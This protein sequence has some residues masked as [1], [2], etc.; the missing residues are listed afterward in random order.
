MSFSALAEVS[1]SDA[2][3]TRRLGAP[4]GALV[5]LVG[6]AFFKLATAGSLIAGGEPCFGVIIRAGGGFVVDACF[7][8]C[9]LIAGVWLPRCAFALGTLCGVVGAVDV[10]FA[11]RFG[12]P[13][14]ASQLA[15][16]SSAVPVELGWA[17][18][19][20]LVALA[21]VVFLASARR[22]TQPHLIGSVAVLLILCGVV[23][24]IVDDQ[25]QRRRLGLDDSPL[26]SLL[27]W[28]H[29]PATRAGDADLAISDPDA[30][31]S[32]PVDVDRQ[33][34]RPRHV[35]LFVS[36]STALGFVDDST[37]PR[38]MAL[39]GGHAASFQEHSAQSPISIK[40][41]FSLL[42]G[43]H[44]DPTSELET[45]S[46]ARIA[47]SS[48]SE[49]LSAQGFDAALFHGGYFAFTD[50]LA[51]L[52][53]RGF[54]RLVD[55]EQLLA[56]RAAAGGKQP[57]HN[58]WGV[59]D[60]AVVDDALSWFDERSD[61]GAA[62][63]L[64]VIPLVPHHEYFLPPDAATPFGVAT[65]VDRYKNGLRFADDVFA[66]LVDGYRARG[67][68]DDTLFVFVGDHGE[69]FDEHPRN[70]L[71]GSFLYEEN[72][73]APLVMVSTTLFAQAQTSHRPSSHADLLPTILDLL[74]VPLP[75]GAPMQGQSLVSSS[76]LPRPVPLFTAVPTLKVGLRTPSLKLVH[77]DNS[78]SD[79]LFDLSRDP[80]EQ[81]NLA[82]T[83]P[84]LT[85][86]MR[87]QALAFLAQQP[88]KLRA[89]GT[90]GNGTWL[91]RAA[92]AAGLK[93]SEHRVFNMERQCIAVQTS[94][95]T[96]TVLRF[97][98]LDPPARTF[99]VGVSDESR[100]ARRGPISVD[101]EGRAVPLVVDDGF[102]SCSRVVE[103]AAASSLMVTIAPSLTGASGCVWMAP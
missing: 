3:R 87:S 64:V 41:I 98:R 60:R 35:V 71:H 59:D 99:G 15:W 89:V 93:L 10:F 80:R 75:A 51:F 96:P 68:F 18:L 19:S 84:A 66:R 65:V 50:K 102:M 79:E 8:F 46:L 70:R 100:A 92:V 72:I 52:G 42:C 40:A 31:W 37:M 76:F 2:H 103:I 85:A 69:A 94:T 91:A 53:E 26:W 22:P 73:R 82:S 101:I 14:T 6:C 62:S 7:A 63:L 12:A 20:A 21:V 4:A 24:A 58:G 13:L 29:A 25:D 86:R 81:H 11:L 1:P 45:T 33:G 17:G 39:A 88:K 61:P 30:R 48:L 57:W 49:T 38:L 9:L 36:E 55:G 23:Q 5:A 67:V 83:Q 27:R 78:D 77:D 16:A 90:K 74:G 54:Q 34:P 47:C 43:L 44:P 28:Q 32:A 97:P 56:S 95:T